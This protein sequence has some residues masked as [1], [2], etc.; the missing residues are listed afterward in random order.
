M[1][2]K[3]PRDQSDVFKLVVENPFIQF[4]LIYEDMT[5]TQMY[6]REVSGGIQSTPVKAKDI[7]ENIH[8][9]FI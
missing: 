6:F 4:T 2:G 9:Y 5:S 8:P 1:C 7:L 3:L